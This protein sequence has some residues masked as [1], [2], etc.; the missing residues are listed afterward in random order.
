MKSSIVLLVLFL[1]VNLTACDKVVAD[2]TPETMVMPA[3]IA[4]PATGQPKD[5]GTKVIPSNPDGSTTITIPP[6]KANMPPDI[7]PEPS[8]IKP[9]N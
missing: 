9:Y 4:V 1:G 3:P 5:D 7:V 6:P 2:K 8:T